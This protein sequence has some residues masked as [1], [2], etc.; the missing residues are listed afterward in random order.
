MSGMAQRKE[1][2]EHI[3][4]EARALEVQQHAAGGTHSPVEGPMLYSAEQLAL[5]DVTLSPEAG[6]ERE[7]LVA[8]GIGTGKRRR[9]P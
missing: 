6:N 2:A 5:G 9:R 8:G 3:R 4:D 7:L 1:W